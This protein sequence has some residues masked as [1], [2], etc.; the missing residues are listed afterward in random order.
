[1]SWFNLKQPM[2]KNYT[3]APVDIVNTKAALTQLGY[4]RPPNEIGIQPWTD[5]AMFNGIMQFQKDNGLK[6]DGFMRPGGP[7]EGY[8]NQHLAIAGEGRG[9]ADGDDGSGMPDGTFSNM[10][11]IV[12]PNVDPNMPILTEPLPENAP[13]AYID[14][15]G[16]PRLDGVNPRTRRVLPP[17]RQM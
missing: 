2:G 11:V 15:N 1:M 3:V 12:P 17:I 9:D 16:I 6:V 14:E 5:E 10:P 4:Y 8:I 7:T 13:G